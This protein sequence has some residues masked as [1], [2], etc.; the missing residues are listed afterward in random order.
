MGIVGLFFFFKKASPVIN[1]V[2][3]SLQ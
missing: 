2:I 3:T 1:K